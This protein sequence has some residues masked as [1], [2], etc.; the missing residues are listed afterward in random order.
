MKRNSKVAVLILAGI[1]CGFGAKISLSKN[2][3]LQN[4][5]SQTP[6]QTRSLRDPSRA[7]DISGILSG[8]GSSQVTQA[9]DLFSNINNH[10]DCQQFA[11]QLLENDAN[12]K[13]L[14]LWN[15]V[16]ARWSELDPDGMI[17]FVDGQSDIKLRTLAWEAWAATDPDL[18]AGKVHTLNPPIS[19]SVLRGI[20]SRNPD[21]ALQLA[22]KTPKINTTINDLLKNG[23]GFSIEAVTEILPQAVYDGMRMPLTKYLSEELAKQDPR[24]A[25]AFVKEKG[26]IWADPT[27][28]LFTTLAAENP[29]QAVTLLAEQPSSRSKAISSVQVAKTWA[30]QDPDASLAWVRSQESSEIR[31]ASLV[32][33]ASVVGGED[34][35]RG[36]ALLEEVAWK[37]TGHF[38]AIGK[39]QGTENVHNQVEEHN[40]AVTHHVGRALL[41]N[42]AHQDPDAARHYI[43]TRVPENRREYLLT[44]FD[45]PKSE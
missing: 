31:E 28:K 7:L 17:K 24:A 15:I 45:E 38:Y 23:E 21:L 19:N 8:K 40:V 39:I 4:G 32:A 36:L 10:R 13:S 9:L 41:Q 3:S 2:R 29:A 18:L 22:F 12:K 16:L 27:A 43:N 34:P 11:A 6:V 44:I 42:L 37:T 33:I 25:L 1:A 14:T 5:S 30:S 26:R 35:E 20:A